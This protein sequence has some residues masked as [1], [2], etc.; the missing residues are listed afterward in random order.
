M[1]AFTNGMHTFEVFHRCS[2][3][4]E[5]VFDLMI[6]DIVANIKSSNKLNGLDVPDEVRSAL[7]NVTPRRYTIMHAIVSLTAK[8]GEPPS[9]TDVHAHT[10]IDRTTITALAESMVKLGMITRDEN[11]NNRRARMLALTDIGN[12]CYNV[13]IPIV[14]A[15]DDYFMS[16]GNIN[17]AYIMEHD[18]TDKFTQARIAIND[19]YAKRIAPEPEAKPQSKHAPGTSTSTGKPNKSKHKSSTKSKPKSKLAA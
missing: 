15:I 17:Y 14:A 12:T 10:G 16:N 18:D 2:Q 9:M 13:S 6:K 7:E 8:R 19:D 4:T 3:I 5:S 11:P 1:P